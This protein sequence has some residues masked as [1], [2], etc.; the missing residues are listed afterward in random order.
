MGIGLFSHVT[1]DGTRGNSFKLCQQRFRLDSKKNF[2]T[3]SM[4][5]HWNRMSRAVVESMSL[6]VFKNCVHI[7]TWLSFVLGSAGL[8]GGLH[9][10][11]GL[12]QPQWFS[13]IIKLPV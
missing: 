12:F 11:R 7:K 9:D 4:V 13:D 10:I 8:M 2:F 5:R 3:E 1:S 6:Q